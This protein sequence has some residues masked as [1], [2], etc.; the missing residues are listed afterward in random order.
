MTKRSHNY[1][2]CGTGKVLVGP[3]IIQSRCIGAE[4]YRFRRK[5]S[6][7]DNS[8]NNRRSES[9]HGLGHD[10]RISGSSGSYYTSYYCYYYFWAGIFN[11]TKFAEIYNAEK[12]PG[13]CKDILLSV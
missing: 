9:K 5:R 6:G 10:T 12:T 8:D 11:E 2:S 7:N 3:A 4:Q 13:F 1:N